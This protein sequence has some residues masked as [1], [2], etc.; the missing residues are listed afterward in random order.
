[1]L[2]Y[3]HLSIKAIG[4]LGDQVMIT[5]THPAADN[6]PIKALVAKQEWPTNHNIGTA[7]SGTA[8]LFRSIIQDKHNLH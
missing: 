8:L 3:D 5:Y 1:M 6:L 2:A 7:L 4:E